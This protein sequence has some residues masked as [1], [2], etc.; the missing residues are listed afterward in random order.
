MISMTRRIQALP[1]HRPLNR[2]DQAPIS[3][4][5]KRYRERVRQDRRAGID[6]IGVGLRHGC[7][8][9]EHRLPSSRRSLCG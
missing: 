9:A 2:I 7:P 6:V 1:A 8:Q 3:H 4:I 5:G